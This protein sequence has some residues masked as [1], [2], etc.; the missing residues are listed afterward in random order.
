MP[1]IDR[2]DASFL[3]LIRLMEDIDRISTALRRSKG[4]AL[5]DISVPKPAFSPLELGFLRLV[6]WVYVLYF[7]AGRVDIRFLKEKLGGFGQDQDGNLS[8]HY[9]TVQQL[10]TYLQHNLNWLE[11]HDYDI[12]LGCERWFKKTCKTVMPD[13]DSHWDACLGGL[14]A[15]AV[16]FLEALKACAQKIE[17]DEHPQVFIEEWEFRHRRHLNSYDFDSLIREIAGD[18]GRDVDAVKF[19]NKYQ[20]RWNE[21][22][23]IKPLNSDFLGEARKLIEYTLITQTADVMPINGKDVIAELGVPRGPR[24]GELLE[25]AY[26]YYVAERLPREKLLDRLRESLS[27]GPA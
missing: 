2:Y 23:S 9:Y 8:Q 13:N 11:E 27:S 10:R 7:E 16:G 6:S 25:M 24:V 26:S 18:I 21:E 20:G 4:R 5:K 15:E 12:K 1:S 19:R 17:G 14:L 22:L 3:N